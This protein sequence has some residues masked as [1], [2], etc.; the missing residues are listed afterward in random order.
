MTTGAILGK[1]HTYTPDNVRDLSRSDL[2][3]ILVEDFG[4]K[5]GD[6]IYAP[7]Y[8]R[9]RFN[10][11]SMIKFVLNATRLRSED[12]KER[13]RKSVPRRRRS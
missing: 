5:L 2:A 9:Y 7:P 1:R 11:A 12:A 13:R 8:G 3:L 10:R 4:W 6:L